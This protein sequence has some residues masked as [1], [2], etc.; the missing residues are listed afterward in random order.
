MASCFFRLVFAGP[1][2]IPRPKDDREKSVAGS[3][4]PTVTADMF[5][6]EPAGYPRWCRTCEVIKPDRAH[7]SRD[8]GRCTYRMGTLHPPLV[9]HSLIWLNTDVDHFCPWVGGMVG[10]SRYKFF[11]QFVSYTAIFCSF[12]VGSVAPVILSLEEY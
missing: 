5:V 12:V 10:F 6:C 4:D 8:C 3:P 7:H 2:Y 9:F 1:G 11:L